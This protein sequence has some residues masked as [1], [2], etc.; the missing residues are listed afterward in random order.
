M[1]VRHYVARY[2]AAVAEMYGRSQG[3]TNVQIER[4]A[5]LGL[6]RD[7]RNRATAILT[8]NEQGQ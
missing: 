6:E 5:L 7:G 8:V 3:A 1:E 2:S 4:A